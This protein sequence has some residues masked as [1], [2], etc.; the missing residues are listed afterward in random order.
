MVQLA[1]VCDAVMHVHHALDPF[2]EATLL[3]MH[4]DKEGQPS[5]HPDQ[6]EELACVLTLV[7]K[8]PEAFSGIHDPAQ[9]G[10]ATTRFRYSIK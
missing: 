3:A 4:G 10:D 7:D 2:I 9:I 5:L 8:A 6:L 1:Q